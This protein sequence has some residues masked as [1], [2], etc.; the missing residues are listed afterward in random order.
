MLVLSPQ[1]G[2]P[3]IVLL[4]PCAAKMENEGGR[5]AGREKC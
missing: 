3:A 4:D 2:E 1:N 5:V